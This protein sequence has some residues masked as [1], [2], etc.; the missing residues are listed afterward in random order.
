MRTLSN[1]LQRV[2][3]NA[4]R[5]NRGKLNIEGVYEK[6]LENNADR[7]IIIERWKGGPGRIKLYTLP[8]TSEAFTTLHLS[9]VKLQDEV[10]QRKT[11]RGDLVVTLG[12]NASLSAKN[13]ADTLSKFLRTP[14]LGEPTTGIKASI[15]FSSLQTGKVKISFTMPPMVNE[16]GPTLI[17]E[18]SKND[19]GESD[20]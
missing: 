15:H 5:I 11:I 4:I 10:G 20:S 1:D 6:A 8:F 16:V 17:V 13:L 7:I 19:T 12:K 3:P 18:N 14:L 9:G 2:L